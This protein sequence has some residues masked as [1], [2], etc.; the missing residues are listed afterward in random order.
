VCILLLSTTLISAS[1]VLGDF[2]DKVE[3]GNEIGRTL[4]DEEE[5]SGYLKQEWTKIVE[6][7]WISGP[8]KFADFLLTKLDPVW[9][10]LI[11]MNFTFS[12]IF[13]VTLLI[14][15][16]FLD[17]AYKLFDLVIILLYS[18]PFVNSREG[19]RKF[20]SSFYTKIGVFLV[21]VV[22]IAR[23]GLPKFLAD[24]LI[25]FISG[26]GSVWL[27]LLYIIIA[28]VILVLL[29]M[30]SGKIKAFFKNWSATRK[31]WEELD[32][33]RREAKMGARSEAKKVIAESKKKEEMAD[34]AKGGEGKKG[35]EKVSKMAEK[36]DDYFDELESIGRQA[37]GKGTIDINKISNKLP[38]KSKDITRED[39]D[40]KGL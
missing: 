10:F 26:K 29:I 40:K 8:L 27:Q 37:R 12:W 9:M 13:F 36:I 4:T 24:H 1:D 39:L 23:S 2:K 38:S 19:L 6:D 31:Y 33:N 15:I 11:G 28:A 25:N 5:R 18:I 35:K 21:F 7:S 30:F 32:N 14:L 17:Y 34:R 3:K 22:A 16:F 20:L